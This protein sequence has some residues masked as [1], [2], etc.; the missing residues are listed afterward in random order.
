MRKPPPAIEWHIAE[1]EAD[2]A[3]FGATQKDD[4][5]SVTVRHL[6]FYKN[7]CWVVN[8]ASITIPPVVGNKPRWMRR[9]WQHFANS[10]LYPCPWVLCATEAAAGQLTGLS[11]A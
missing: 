6:S 2:W 9:C 3:R 5:A 11:H 10:K 8:N 7:A 1:N 4:S